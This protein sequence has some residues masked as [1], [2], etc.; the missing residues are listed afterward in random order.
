MTWRACATDWTAVCFDDFE[1][2]N[3]GRDS[4]YSAVIVYSPAD[5]QRTIRPEESFPA[6]LLVRP[7]KAG[8][9]T[10]VDPSKNRTSH[11]VSL[12][13]LSLHSCHAPERMVTLT[14]GKGGPRAAA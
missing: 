9:Q 8:V 10:T 1:G 6:V 14:V 3:S 7:S 11:S 13:N 4:R 5:R 12:Y 2:A